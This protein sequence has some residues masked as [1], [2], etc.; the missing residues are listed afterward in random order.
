MTRPEPT[1][2]MHYVMQHPF[3]LIGE[4][5]LTENYFF[6]L[7]FLLLLLLVG[8]KY[9]CDSYLLS[10]VTHQGGRRGNPHEGPTE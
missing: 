2:K 9:P 5:H 6:W 8:V 7:F 3:R 4:S 10:T 1:L